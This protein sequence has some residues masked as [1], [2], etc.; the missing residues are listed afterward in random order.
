MLHECTLAI[1]KQIGLFKTTGVANSVSHSNSGKAVYTVTQRAVSK[2]VWLLLQ[3]VS[4]VSCNIELKILHGPLL[5]DTVIIFSIK[6]DQEI[7]VIL[8]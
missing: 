2:M 8:N 7:V 5:H 6:F 1:N 3:R 4:D